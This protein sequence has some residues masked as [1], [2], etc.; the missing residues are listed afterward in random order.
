MLSVVPAANVVDHLREFHGPVGVYD[1]FRDADGQI[2]PQWERILKAFQSGGALNLADRWHSA[3]RLLQENG[4][5]FTG[6]DLQGRQSR[7][8]KLDLL[9]IVYSASDW[10]VLRRGITQRA[11]LIDAII[12]D[13]YGPQT[14]L[15]AGLLPPE[16][17]FRNLEYQRIFFGLPA[18]SSPLLTYGCELARSSTGQWWVMADRASAPAGISFAVENRIVL[19]KTL[20]QFL[21]TCQIHRLAP[22]FVTLQETMKE[23]SEQRKGN[24]SVVILSAGPEHPYYYEDV[25]LARYLGYPLLEADDLTIRRN[26]VWIKTLRGLIPVDVIIRRSP[27]HRI[28]PL[29]ISSPD[30]VAGLLQVIRHKNVVLVNGPQNGLLDSPVYMPFLPQLCRHL[31][32]EDLR[33]PSIATW[34]CGQKEPLAYVM[35]HLDD[36]VIKPAFAHSGSEEMIISEMSDEAV[37]KLREK[38]LAQPGSF[39]AQEK[40]IRSTAPCL[41]NHEFCSGHIALRTFAVRKQD[42]FELMDGGLVRVETSPKPMQLSVSA[43]EFSKDVWVCSETPVPPVTLLG[44]MLE[45]PRIQRASSKLPSRA[46]D[47][48]FWLGRYLER[49]EFSGRLIRKITDRL[50]SESANQPVNDVVP[51]ITCLAEQGLI[52]ESFA[53][54][55]FFPQRSEL[56]KLWP[57]IIWGQADAARFEGLCQQVGRIASIVRDRMTEDFWRAVSQISTKVRPEQITD[58]S[59]MY[60]VLNIIMLHVS[61]TTGQITDGLVHGPTRQFILIGRYLER[62]RQLLLVL[63]QYL[64]RAEDQETLPLITLLD[65]CNSL[66]TYRYR[67]RANFAVLPAFDLLVTDASNPHALIF[68]FHEMFNL[69][70][71]LPGQQKRPLITPEL[72]SIRRITFELQSLLPT[73]DQDLT[74]RR[75]REPLEQIFKTLEQRINE[76]SDL[77]SQTY[78]LHAEF[79]QQIDETRE[80]GVS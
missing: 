54:E 27:D 28:D 79:T 45:P 29:E 63:R 7:P 19:S 68:Q 10:D 4:V 35:Q 67:Y 77:L 73:R 41:V 23:F 60:D 61:A 37:A 52:E 70:S 20:P 14:V 74:W 51:L 11:R 31:L 5:N 42:D 25:F 26:Q 49:L 76:L 78:F 50:M 55:D 57:K 22:Y 44:H 72:D 71:E 13:L 66:M 46:A 75:Y 33:L 69:V 30:G 48:L 15:K 47:N 18:S 56:E 32:G 12:Q 58:L 16:L 39:I 40:I 43:G 17:V 3:N 21:H 65:V 34:W 62:A 53:L 9:P 1:E 8:W 59:E 64:E 36:L 80:S 2:R 6:Y 24:P 38:I